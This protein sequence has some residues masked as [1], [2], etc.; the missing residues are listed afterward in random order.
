[1]VEYAFLHMHYLKGLSLDLNMW[2]IGFKDKGGDINLPSMSAIRF[3]LD[4]HNFDVPHIPTT[5]VCAPPAP[6]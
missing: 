1:M 4:L 6:S 3:D 2:F 5:F